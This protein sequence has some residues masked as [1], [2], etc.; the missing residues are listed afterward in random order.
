MRCAAAFFEERSSEPVGIQGS[1]FLSKVADEAAADGVSKARFVRTA[2]TDPSCAL[3]KGMGM[4]CLQSM[5]E[6]VRA[7]GRAF[8]EG[9]DVPVVEWM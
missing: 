9:S 6:T 4:V 1:H 2:H 3:V 5:H 7:S 8:M